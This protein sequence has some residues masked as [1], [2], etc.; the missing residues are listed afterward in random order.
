M[1]FSISRWKPSSTVWQSGHGVTMAVAPPDLGGLDVL[2]GQLDRDPLVV[3]GGME[4]A[5]F[6]AP[7]VVD[8]ATTQKLGEPLERDVVAGI[9]EAVAL[10]RARDV[11]AV[12]GG[13]AEPVERPDHQVAQA[14]DADILVQ[15]PE[16]VADA[17]SPA[18]TQA[19][20]GECDVHLC[21]SSGSST[22]A[23]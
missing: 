5:A 15:H 1:S 17:G 19:L 7:A 11:A 13:D 10:R 6:G 16:E 8:G 9:D 12:E 23:A 14:L 3:G 20:V 18:V 21:A 2:P 22:N 4:P